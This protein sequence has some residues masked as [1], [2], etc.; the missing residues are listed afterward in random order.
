MHDVYLAITGWH[1]EGIDYPAG[2][3][4]AIDTEPKPGAIYV[5]AEVLEKAIANG[6]LGAGVVEGVLAEM[7]GEPAPIAPTKDF[8]GIGFG[9]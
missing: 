9:S 3:E 1:H 8:S 6:I 5:P 7:V 4:I 2:T